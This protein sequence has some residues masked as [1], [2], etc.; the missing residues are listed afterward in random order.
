MGKKKLIRFE[1]TKTFDNIFQ[2]E[3]NE[4][5]KDNFFL[6]GKWASN[7]FANNNPI[8]LELACGK[9]EYTISLAQKFP[10]KNFIGI[11][12]KGARLWRGCKN[13]IDNKIKNVAFLRTRIELIEYFFASNEISEIWITFPDPQPNKPNKRLTAFN[14]IEKY[15]KVCDKNAIVHLKTDNNM[16]YQFT[17]DVIKEHNLKLLLNSDDIYNSNILDDILSIKTFYEL[18]FI[19]MGLN[20]HYL[21]FNI[22]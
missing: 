9:G 4:A 19:N 12:Y 20:I 2:I 6:K 14:F 21:K 5:I 15:T 13:A 22:N 17:L 10:N 7:F 8:V 11:D 18:K 16:L 3:Y 1:E